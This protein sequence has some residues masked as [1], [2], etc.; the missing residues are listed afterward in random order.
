ME[1]IMN[2]QSLI[3]TISLLSFYTVSLIGMES[4]SNESNNKIEITDQDIAAINAILLEDLDQNDQ[5]ATKEK[6]E[7]TNGIDDKE[8]QTRDIKKETGIFSLDAQPR[9]A[10]TMQAVI[11]ELLLPHNPYKSSFVKKITD[12][13]TFE[14]K[15]ISVNG[16][17]HAL[18]FRNNNKSIG[19]HWHDPK[20]L[21][22]YPSHF[23]P[24]STFTMRLDKVSEFN[25][26]NNSLMREFDCAPARG[27]AFGKN[28][29]FFALDDGHGLSICSDLED[30]FDYSIQSYRTIDK[31]DPT[32]FSLVHA[33]LNNNLDTLACA[34]GLNQ[35]YVM[36]LDIKPSILKKFKK[37]HEFFNTPAVDPIDIEKDRIKARDSVRSLVFHPTDN[38]FLAI[39]YNNHK[40]IDLYDLTEHLVKKSFDSNSQT[41]ALAFSPDG[42]ILAAGCAKPDTCTEMQTI[43]L[44]DVET[45]TL[46]ATINAHNDTITTLAFSPNGKLLAS[47]SKSKTDGIFLWDMQPINELMQF[48][49]SLSG[50][51]TGAKKF[52]LLNAIFESNA[53]KDAKGNPKEPKPFDL[54][55][56]EAIALLK[57]LPIWLKKQLQKKQMV[58]VFTK[59]R[60]E[61]KQ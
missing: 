43:D 12:L 14:K 49:R 17:I 10:A 21:K 32:T 40:S 44:W 39:G 37:L 15:S 20:N 26:E 46:I 57:D 19:Y 53:N 24:D 18:M 8:E 45:G 1:F 50:D 58:R 2:K 55:Q 23:A 29:D 34:M 51:C 27:S 4:S 59:K 3:F 22:T 38:R 25:L 60:A 11:Y 36:I 7:E 47:G 35:G 41:S 61:N 13:L 28:C 56:P 6:K 33:T 42:K 5:K 52:L 30:D 48:I 31:D 9:K 54:Y 16:S